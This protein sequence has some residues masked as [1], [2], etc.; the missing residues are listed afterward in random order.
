MSEGEIQGEAVGWRH[1]GERRN[2][3]FRPG[4]AAELPEALRDEGWEGFELLSTERALADAPG[5]AN[6][7]EALH[8][9]PHGQVPE[10]A[11]ARADRT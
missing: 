11:A 4:L 3:V 5:L 1:Q 6:A 2:V 8:L 7:A 9:V 10:A